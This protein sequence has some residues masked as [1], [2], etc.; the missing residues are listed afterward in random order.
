M[1]ADLVLRAR[2]D[3]SALP[4]RDALALAARVAMTVREATAPDAAVPVEQEARRGVLHVTTARRDVPQARR[5]AVQVAL[6]AVRVMVVRARRGVARD[7]DA[8][9]TGVPPVPGIDRLVPAP[10]ARRARA[11]TGARRRAVPAASTTTDPHARA[12]TG[13]SATAVGHALATTHDAVLPPV[14]PAARSAMVRPGAAAPGPVAPLVVPVGLMTVRPVAPDDPTTDLVVDLGGQTTGPLVDLGE[15]MTVRRVVRAD[16]L[17]VRL[18][19]RAGRT[20]PIARAD[21]STATAVGP[22]PV[23]IA[24]AVT[25]VPEATGTTAGRAVG[26]FEAP[27]APASGGQ[28]GVRPKSR[29]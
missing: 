24:T 17:T 19:G 12:A 28:C 29:A 23:A 15:A 25:L 14:V 13:R 10:V 27:L 5:E 11:V 16:R 26:R 1:P 6:A 4:R 21:R 9:T 8:V 22:V 7:H 18:V 2:P 20:A 3:L